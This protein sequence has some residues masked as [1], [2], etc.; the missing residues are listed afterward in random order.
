MNKGLLLAA[1]LLA[2]SVQTEAQTMISKNHIQLQSDCM[3][4]EALW[5]MGRI[6]GCAASPDGKKIAYQVGYYSVKENKGHQML[7]VMDAD[8]KNKRQLT[9]TAKSETDVAWIEGGKKLAFLC[10]G[11]LFTEN[12]DGTDRKQVSESK[13]DIE[14][15]RFS[16]DGKKVILIK[17]LP[18]HGSIKQNPSDLPKATGMVITDLN[19]RHW[20]HYVTT[21]L[22]PFVANVSANGMIDEGKD[23]LAGENYECPTAP[24]GGIEQLA[25]SVDRRS[26]AYTCRKKEGVAY[27]TSFSANERPHQDHEIPSHRLRKIQE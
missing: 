27:A 5:A 8:G 3:T 20:D 2:G 4:P 6:G 26:V 7:F 25:W 24:F 18:Y 14:G 12:P 9:Q 23:I 13:T 21:I 1:A 11:Q 15:F 17:S 19:Y 22:H 10:D 16:P